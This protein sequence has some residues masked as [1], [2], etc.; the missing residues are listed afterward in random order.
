MTK[1]CGARCLVTSLQAH[2]GAEPL[3]CGANRCAMHGGVARD[4]APLSR[5][6][7]IAGQLTARVWCVMS[8]SARGVAPILACS[9]SSGTTIGVSECVL[10]SCLDCHPHM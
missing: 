6:D 10:R 3:R 4:A 8:A 9:D 5:A 1:L 7:L 2:A